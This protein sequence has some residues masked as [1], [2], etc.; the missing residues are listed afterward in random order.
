M[1]ILAHVDHGKTTL[2][3]HLIGSNGLIHPR[4]MGEL[5][6]LDSRDD[7]RRLPLAV[8]GGARSGVTGPDTMRCCFAAASRARRARI[9]ASAFSWAASSISSMRARF[10]SLL[11]S[12]NLP[13]SFCNGERS[14][15]EGLRPTFS[16]VPE[17]GSTGVYGG[18]RRCCSLSAGMVTFGCW[19][20]A[21]IWMVG[22][23]ERPE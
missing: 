4:L 2:S 19:R 7:D 21:I 3:D 15:T 6:Y 13:S 23:R 12:S 9:S 11:M 1:C 18:E 22:S 14:G 10:S 20:P 8:R 17:S 5:R 16:K